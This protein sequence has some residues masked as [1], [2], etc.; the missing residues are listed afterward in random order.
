MK[1]RY[2]K[3]FTYLIGYLYA[4]VMVYLASVLFGDQMPFSTV[5]LIATVV[6]L[7]VSLLLAFRISRI[8]FC[9]LLGAA[10][11][12][13]S[14]LYITGT[15]GFVTDQ[16][17]R[18]VRLFERL[19][20][21]ESIPAGEVG[22]TAL[23]F[24]I[25]ASILFSVLI[26]YL[27]NRFFSFFLITAAIFGMLY[28]VRFF[29]G[30][31]N[32]T[33]LAAA[34]MLTAISFFR[35]VYEKKLKDG[36]STD[37]SVPGS[38]MLFSLPVVIIPI[39]IVMSV[40]K[41]DYP[42]QWP[43]LDQKVFQ[44]FQYLEQK[45]GH[46]DTE[47]FS[48]TSAGFSSSTS[49][50][51]GPV[52]PSHTI[53]MEIK[54]NKRTYLR[55]AAYSRYENNMWHR[56]TLDQPDTSEVETTLLENRTGWSHIPVDALFPEV[57]GDDKELL[58]NLE[59]GSTNPFLFPT[60]TLEIRHRNMTTKTVFTPLLTILPI[61]GTGGNMAVLQDIHGITYKEEKLPMGSQY[62]MYYAQPMYGAPMLKRALN[63]SYDTLY[64]DALNEQIKKRD[65]LIEAGS[66]PEN[67][68]L[69]E[70]DRDIA[71]LEFFLE[72]S[73]QIEE[74]YTAL[75]EDIPERVIRLAQNIT[76][77]CTTDYERVVTIENYLR[78]NYQYTLSPS[79]V[80]EGRDFTDW[81]LFED[82]RGYCTYF[83]TSMT[84]MLRSLGIPARYVEG[85]V[86]PEKHEDNVYTIT[87]RNAHAWV[88]VYFQGFGWL[89]FEPTPI[90][91]DVMQY[92][93]S[94]EN[95]R[96]V[97]M[98]AEDLEAMMKRYADMYGKSPNVPPAASGGA[99]GFSIKPYLKYT[100]AAIAGLVVLLIFINLLAVL[101]DNLM[102]LGKN[103]K[104]KAMRLFQIMLVWLR[105]SGCSIRPGET[106]A[107]FARRVDKSF[108]LEQYTFTDASR[109][110]CRVRYGDKE[111]TDDDLQII[112]AT[113]RRLKK[114]L[115]KGLGVR[116]F[117][118]LRRVILRI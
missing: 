13:A 111:V 46:T 80:P 36:T 21:L 74:E 51:G 100:P 49:R 33:A 114:L 69:G 4:L 102:L 35:H 43:W 78:N 95:V 98:S 77:D 83:A 116:R 118:P 65:A 18:I 87:G 61:T 53:M 56:D 63:F 93:P 37:R 5:L 108:A 59:S 57:E 34:C 92:L 70:L 19:Y 89:T 66:L 41:S 67:P 88:E 106:V 54:G 76:Y 30:S 8:I 24:V 32:R 96:S 104:R 107:E 115:V 64:L 71:I 84:V 55:G 9:S 12:A 82:K 101:V 62:T 42:I 79:Q 15:G 38:L 112:K 7:A 40:P 16:L 27:F 3:V 26:Y 90:Y 47:F 97:D 29:T 99:S 109:I 110:F 73:R 28:L 105:H 31:T 91:A 20:Y 117:L 2:D 14:V 72:R 58:M 22:S 60:M 103:N 11:I 94:P 48:L 10:V 1:R 44:L 17:N 39:L 86:M 75:S 25:L 113:A 50:L 23:V 52:R 81:F 85:F 6:Y 45:F 68:V